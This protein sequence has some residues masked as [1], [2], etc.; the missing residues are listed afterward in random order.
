MSSEKLAYINRELSWIEFNQRVLDEACDDALPL[1][2]RLKFLAITSSNL[3]EFFMVRVGGLQLLAESG[4]RKPDPSGWSPEEQ[5]DAVSARV[6][7]ML[8]QQ[9][10][11]F[12][13][14]LEPKLAAAGIRRMRINE[15]ND[16]QL[17]PIEQMFDS[18]IFSILTPLAI[19]GDEEIPLLAN[20]VLQLCVRLHPSAEEPDRPRFAVIP[21]GRSVP[22]FLAVAGVGYNFVLFEDVVA[23]FVSRFFPGQEVVEAAAF[24]ITR[25]ADLSL[26]EDQA[27]DLISGMS[28]ILEQRKR[29]D[30]V[31]LELANHASTTMVDFL[32]KRLY[33][34]ERD[35]FL[36]PGPV[37]LSAFFQLCDVAGFDILKNPLWSPQ[38]SPDAPPGESMFAAIAKRDILLYHPYESFSP[39]VRLVEEAAVDPDVLAIKQTLYRTSRASPIVAALARA[40]RAGK[41]VTAIVEL[42]ARFDEARNI[43]WARSLEQ[44]GVQVIYGIKGLKTHAKICI[45]IRREPQGIIRYV[46]FGTGNYNE[47][48]ARIYSDASLLTCNEELGN[49]AVSFFHSI[50]GYS[51]PPRFHKLAAAPLGLRK[52]VLDMIEAETLRAR[53]EERGEI[54][55]KMNSL[56]DPELIAALYEASQA[57]VK[58]RLNIR[59]I[60]CLKPGL[61]GVSDNIEVVSIVDRF[62][63]HARIFHFYHGGDNRVFISSADWMQRNLDKRIELLVPIEDPDIRRRLISILGTYFDDNIKGRK[64]SSDGKWKRVKASGRKKA[65]RSQEVLQHLAEQ[66]ISESK[67]QDGAVFEPHRAPGNE[68]S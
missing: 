13:S 64:L 32:R 38:E 43:E 18:E 20:Q 5:L 68:E 56:V 55:A 15:L 1:L 40:A 61:K 2:E 37:D 7:D 47:A 63:E 44:A 58:I 8:S 21:L 60:C 25:N 22:R 3:D 16:R 62:L 12:Q 28:K 27:P 59:G 45:V 17:R 42:K 48:T 33:L 10:E 50:T 9:Y 6:R 31:R 19:A 23:H 67:R 36:A 53:N 24:R 26:Q 41:Y 30:C 52:K 65:I 49:D 57:G 34:D 46:H 35:V 54:V 14:E 11:C 66:R 4:E 29:S 39:V 51:Q